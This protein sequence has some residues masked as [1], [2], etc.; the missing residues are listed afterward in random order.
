MTE[1]QKRGA[2]IIGIIVI[3]LLLFWPK[4]SKAIQTNGD[5]PTID[6]PAF[7]LPP[8]NEYP[9]QVVGLPSINIDYPF[10]AISACACGGGSVPYYF[11]EVTQAPS[12]AP[13][14]IPQ[15]TNTFPRF[16]LG[17]YHL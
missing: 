9:I 10:N 15:S 12:P 1:N 3:I 14:N 4:T 5:L 17:G 2:I 13:I 6:I 11:K 7:N 8:R 16:Y